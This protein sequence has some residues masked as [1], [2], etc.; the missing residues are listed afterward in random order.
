MT[1]YIA[2][3]ISQNYFLAGK[4]EKAVPFFERIARTLRREKWW[5]MLHS[6]LSMWYSCVK[7]LGEVK[8][9]VQILV[10]MMATPQKPLPG[11]RYDEELLEILK[12]N[13][14]DEIDDASEIDFYNDYCPCELAMI[15]CILILSLRLFSV[16]SSL[17]FWEE[18]VI[19]GQSTPFQL[20]LESDTDISAIPF[21]SLTL[22]F[23]HEGIEPLTIHQN[24]AMAN[25]E[26]PQ[27]I[28]VGNVCVKNEDT[29]FD[30]N[31]RWKKGGI[32]VI[33][34][35]MSLET[36]VNLTVGYLLINILQL[37]MSFRF[38]KLS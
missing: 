7:Q 3:L 16:R 10:E 28:N 33:M 36:P 22:W 26:I 19:V 21:S 6:L 13:I 4:L 11:R 9:C 1:H 5:V 30:A 2:F 24:T 29:V 31:L 38:R 27:M 18:S 23:S 34:G 15:L 12:E 14:P 25:P 35:S 37:L 32:L 17:I 20:I 8:R